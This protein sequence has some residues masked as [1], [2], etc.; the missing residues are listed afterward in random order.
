MLK[1]TLFVIAL[2][3]PVIGH[4]AVY[5]CTVN[6]QTVFSDQP[7]GNDAQKIEVRA[8]RVQGG[9]SM[10]NEGVQDFLRDRQQKQQVERIDR[11]ITRLER[12]KATARQNMEAAIRRYES[13][14]SRANNNLA[15]AV[16]EGSLAE[17]AEIQRQRYQSEI[18]GADREIDRLRQE[19]RRILDQD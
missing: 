10:A 5:Q 16:W 17:G 3:S 14:R 1:R 7:C 12:Q 8:P 9:G 6:G 18:D 2:T 19:R 13:D 4:G 15:G 11:D